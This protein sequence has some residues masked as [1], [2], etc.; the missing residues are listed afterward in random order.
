MKKFDFKNIKKDIISGVIVALV[1]IPISMGYS[2][3]AGLPAVYGLY[4]SILP[5]F[6]YGILTSSPQFVFGV[7]ATPAALVGGTLAAMGI[8]SGSDEA[9]AVVPVI[10]LVAALWLLLF[11]FV[12]AGRIVKYISAPVMGGFISGIGVTI[13]LMQTAKLFGGNA[14]TGEVVMLLMH[15]WGQLDSFNLF[16]AVLGVGTVVIILVAKRF[17][18]K[19]PMSVL[20]MFLG[21]GATAV[22]H[23]DR[24][25]VNLLPHVE[26]GLP[27]L[28]LPDMSIVLDNPAN[29]ILLGLSV[30]GVLIAL[31]LVAKNNFAKKYK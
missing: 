2:Q 11:F 14:G 7:D 30:A 8:V 29:I 12:K 24:F 3:I 16:S 4:C 5:V 17:I 15:I 18:P 27:G 22:F 26:P 25:G 13:I 20:L 9:K 1:S 19:F 31:T 10:T 21:A 28:S 6:I 23:I